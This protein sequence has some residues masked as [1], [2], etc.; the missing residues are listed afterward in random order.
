MHSGIATNT[1]T[2]VFWGRAKAA[3]ADAGDK[4]ILHRASGLVQDR[5]VYPKTTT[6][7][8]PPP[9]PGKISGC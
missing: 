5:C 7:V 4:A 1:A 8:P 2:D 6:G 9:R 3:W